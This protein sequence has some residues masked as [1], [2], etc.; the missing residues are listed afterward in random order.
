MRTVSPKRAR[1]NRIRRQLLDPLIAEGAPCEA[2][3][4]GCARRATD[5][6]EVKTR[7]RGGS[8]TDMTNIEMVCRSCHLHITRTSG[9]NEW[10]ARH[11]HVVPSWATPEAEALAA[12]LRTVFHCPVECE[13]DHRE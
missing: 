8:I 4:E 1:M 5:G 7:A 6:H 13:E 11:G 12:H 2:G 9:V 3:L 10:A